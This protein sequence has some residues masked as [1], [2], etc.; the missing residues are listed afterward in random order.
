MNVTVNV[1]LSLSVE[2]ECALTLLI[3]EK[4]QDIRNRSLG[5][6]LS[7]T[8]TVRAW[9][10]WVHDGETHP[11]RD[12]LR[13]LVGSRS[14]WK[15]TKERS[16]DRWAQ[17]Q[18]KEIPDDRLLQTLYS[19]LAE[20]HTRTMVDRQRGWREIESIAHRWKDMY[21]P[22]LGRLHTRV[23][24]WKDTADPK[25]V[26]MIQNWICV[27]LGLRATHE[28]ED[29]TTT[30]ASDQLLALLNKLLGFVDG[31]PAN[32]ATRFNELAATLEQVVQAREERRRL[33]AAAERQPVPYRP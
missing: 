27:P 31:M 24:E 29:G 23:N 17:E 5:E 32:V 2:R 6:E 20:M 22:L 25:A 18:E 16:K 21:R 15:W 8:T 14:E 28:L 3:E 4:I 13:A 1:P 7:A 30:S 10:A 33:G 26:D 11:P 9:Y 12:L 19:Y